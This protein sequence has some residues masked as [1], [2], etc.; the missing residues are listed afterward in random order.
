M[1]TQ[2]LELIDLQGTRNIRAYCIVYWL[3]CSGTFCQCK[4]YWDLVIT[5]SLASLLTPCFVKHS[6]Y[7]ADF[8]HFQETKLLSE[9]QSPTSA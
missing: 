1:T 8:H 6:N 9:Q 7:K 4:I 3:D 2:C 5:L